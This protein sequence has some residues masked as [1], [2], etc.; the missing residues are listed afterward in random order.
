MKKTKE[1]IL[2]TEEPRSIK[3]IGFINSWGDIGEN[4]WQYIGEEWLQWLWGLTTAV[5]L[6]QPVTTFKFE[7]DLMYGMKHDDVKELQKYLNKNGYKVAN[8][9]AGSP[10]NETNY[11]GV[12]TKNALVRFQ[13]A[14][15][16]SPAV[17]Y[18]GP[19]TRGFI[20]K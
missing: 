12:L 14:N 19:I 8:S 1:E 15:R 20:N 3:L 4:G 17:G 2:N 5:V 18:F 16:I 6:P 11:F 10:G 7:R 13:K 9:G